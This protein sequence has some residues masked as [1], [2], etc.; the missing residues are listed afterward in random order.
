MRTST[1]HT[2]SGKE[3][4]PVEAANEQSY[5]QDLPE[6]HRCGKPSTTGSYCELEPESWPMSPVMRNRQSGESPLARIQREAQEATPTVIRSVRVVG[7]RE[8]FHRRAKIASPTGH[9]EQ[10]SNDKFVWVD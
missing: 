2:T 6:C 1:T 5:L 8:G 9:W 4:A 7:Q 3:R 10:D